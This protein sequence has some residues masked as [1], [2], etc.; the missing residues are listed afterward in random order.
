MT[1]TQTVSPRRQR[2]REKLLDGARAVI[3]ESG[4]HGASVEEICDRAGFTRGA[5]YSNFADK[6]ELVL[7][8]FADD[9][10]AL[11]ERLRAALDEESDDLGTVL[12]RV[13]AS[14]EVGDLR[15]WYL[16]RTEMTL[17][18]L[19]TPAVASALVRARADFRTAVRDAVLEAARRTG[20]TPTLDVDLLVR[21]VEAL[22]DG[23]TAQSLLEP[24]A[25]PAG[26]LLREVLPRLLVS[27]GEKP[28]GR[29]R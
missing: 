15:T 20:H 1:P 16:V 21:A 22:H 12:S 18:A 2:T 13:V 8:L 7:A 27:T 24:R 19:R 23:A 26:S 6:D 3:A 25:L 14:M 11:L 5:F 17:H 9:R 28:R 29:S 4:V 10:A